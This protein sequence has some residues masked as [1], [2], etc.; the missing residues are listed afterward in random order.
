MADN[1]KQFRNCK[2]A[3]LSWFFDDFEESTQVQLQAMEICGACVVRTQCLEW[4]ISEGL[5][6]CFV[7]GKYI[8]QGKKKVN[9]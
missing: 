9:A 8:K 6:G 7:G 5:E 4:A 3:P 2:D 1:W